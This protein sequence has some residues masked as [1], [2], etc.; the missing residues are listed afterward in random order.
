M[1]CVVPGKI[2]GISVRL[3]WSIGVK[4]DGTIISAGVPGG[5]KIASHLG[6]ICMKFQM[7]E[8]LVGLLVD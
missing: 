7:C 2:V 3:T 6:T 4:E 8:V 5:L 1:G